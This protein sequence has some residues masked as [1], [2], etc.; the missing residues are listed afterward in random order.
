MRILLSLLAVGLIGIAGCGDKSLELKIRYDAIH[1]LV[2]DA[3]VLFETSAIGKVT[4]VEFTPEGDYLVHVSIAEEFAAAATDYARF[5]IV[6]DPR[7]PDASAVEVIQTQKG[8]QPL[9]DGATIPGAT[10]TSAHLDRLMD[11]LAEGI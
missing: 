10:K 6:P 5:F 2:G 3:P 4:K 11:Q 1:G 8:G 9:Q 7:N